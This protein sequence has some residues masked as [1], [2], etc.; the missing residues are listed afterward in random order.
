MASSTIPDIYAL[1][2]LEKIGPKAYLQY[3]VSILKAGYYAA[4]KRF[5]PLACEAV[6]NAEA[7]QAGIWKLK[8]IDDQEF[9][10]IT[11]RDLRAAGERF[12]V[13]QIQANFIPGGLILGWS[14]LHMFGDGTTFA[15][16]T[17]IW[18]EEY[19]RAQNLDIPN[20]I[21]LP[22]TIFKDRELLMKPSGRNAGH[23]KDHSEY[24][25]LSFT[26]T[27]APLKM[28]SKN[29]RGQ[30]FYFSPEMLQALKKE[31]WPDKARASTTQKWI[32]TNDALSALLWRTV[33]AVHFPL[34]TLEGDSVST[35]NIAIDGQSRTNPPVHPQ[36]LGCFLE[37]VALSLPIREILSS[38]SLADEWTDDI[39][40]LI[41]K[42]VVD[43]DRV[44]PT[45][46]LDVP[47][48]NC[49]QSSGANFA[50]YDLDWGHALGNKI[51][52][53]RSPSNGV[54]NGLQVILPTLPDGGLE[55]LVGVEELPQPVA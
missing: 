51:Q 45:A 52:A 20:P 21:Q 31:A 37:Y 48:F 15:V 28:A 16:W 44:V 24:T 6:P 43:V 25:L 55:V 23:L 34:E 33:M 47:G 1:T 9:E 12:R 32:S 35:F 13:C 19:Q 49:V 7:K 41:D 10:A 18:A 8:P 54:I 29:H 53:V 36:T 38:M 26:P 46:F 14:I 39:T 11:L 5:A 4:S 30:V 17:Q 40:T 3:I 27:G 2:P 42:H 50:L 22:E